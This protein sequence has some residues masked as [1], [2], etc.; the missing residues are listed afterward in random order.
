MSK[1]WAVDAINLNFLTE[2][3][4][5][6]RSIWVLERL[7]FKSDKCKQL[8]FLIFGNIKWVFQKVCLYS[9]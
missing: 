4:S 2:L 1:V 7:H 5:A 9:S 3:D 6:D 8:K